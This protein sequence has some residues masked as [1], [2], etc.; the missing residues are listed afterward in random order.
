MVYDVTGTV[1]L[2]DWTKPDWPIVISLIEPRTLVRRLNNPAAGG[3]RLGMAEWKTDEPDVFGA[4]NGYRWSVWDMRSTRAGNPIATG[5]A[6]G[7]G[8]VPDVFR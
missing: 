5:E 4:V 6:W 7:T 1:K 3:E 2:I 8:I